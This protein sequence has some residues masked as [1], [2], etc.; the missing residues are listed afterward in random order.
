VDGALAEL[1]ARVHRA[2]MDGTWDR[3]KVCPDTTC[4]WAFYD[5]SR[6]RSSRWC[7]MGVC[8]NR[9]KVRAFRERRAG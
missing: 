6:N 1:I 5:G 3:L 2:Q 8:G 7:N 4:H 9:H